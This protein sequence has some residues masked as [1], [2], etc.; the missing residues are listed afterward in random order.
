MFWDRG[1][2]LSLCD[3]AQVGGSGVRGVLHRGSFIALAVEMVSLRSRYA[4]WGR[5]CI[6]LLRGSLAESSYMLPRYAGY[7]D[8]GD[9]LDKSAL[10]KYAPLGVLPTTEAHRVQCI[11]VSG[12]LGSPPTI[13]IP[14]PLKS[15]AVL[16][17]VGTF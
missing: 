2:L 11:T 16:S 7:C 6:S 4:W 14:L 15:A 17:T 13:S 8:C 10:A 9:N 12:D 3:E 5:E 1:S